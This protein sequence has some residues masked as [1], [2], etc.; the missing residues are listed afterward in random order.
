M[1]I[2]EH[3]FTRKAGYATTICNLG[4]NRV[5]DIV[6][7]RSEAALD[8][9]FT[10]LKAKDNVS[11]VVMDL[12]RTYRNIIEKHFP[13]AMIVAD[14]FHVIRLVNHHFLKVWADIDP[15][16]RKVCPL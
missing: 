3:F 7:G 1:G 16:G 11:I 10:T 15:R 2:D 6:L 9:Y 14:R 4:T 5:H 12:S 13:H 8:A